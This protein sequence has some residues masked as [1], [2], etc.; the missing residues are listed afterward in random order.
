MAVLL[1]SLAGSKIKN[2]SPRKGERILGRL[3]LHDLMFPRGW[4]WIWHLVVR[5]PGGQRASSL[6]PL[7]MNQFLKRSKAD[8]IDCQ[9][10][11]KLKRSFSAK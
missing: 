11:V 8:A 5:L 7:H 3:P 6:T 10:G 9:A 2:L 1:S 4:G